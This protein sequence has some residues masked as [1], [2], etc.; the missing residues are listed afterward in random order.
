MPQHKPRG[1][2]RSQQTLRSH[3][4]GGW[5]PVAVVTVYV[6]RSPGYDSGFGHFYWDDHQQTVGRWPDDILNATK[7]ERQWLHTHPRR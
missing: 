6:P 3:T 4:V 7:E 5:T 2:D 1:Y